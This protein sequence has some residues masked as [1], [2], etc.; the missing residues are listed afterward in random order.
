MEIERAFMNKEGLPQS[1]WSKHLVYAPEFYIGYASQPL[2][3]IVRAIEKKNATQLSKELKFLDEALKNA[4]SII[5]KI[6]TGK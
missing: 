6:E 4:T 3:E 1:P 2:P 5:K